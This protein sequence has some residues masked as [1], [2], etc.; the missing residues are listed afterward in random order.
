MQIST[1]VLQLEGLWQQPCW[2]IAS[3]NGIETMIVAT[4][5]GAAQG[6]LG[7][8]LT[9][10]SQVFQQKFLLNRVGMHTLDTAC[11]LDAYMSLPLETGKHCCLVIAMLAPLRDMCSKSPHSSIGPAAVSNVPMPA[12]GPAQG[13]PVPAP[14]STITIWCSQALT[15]QTYCFLCSGCMHACM[16]AYRHFS[17]SDTSWLSGMDCLQLGVARGQ[18][19]LTDFSYGLQ[20]I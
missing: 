15:L 14:H 13:L 10:A 8:A 18:L 3:Q 6:P 1:V 4:I 2:Q 7:D 9:H 12:A 17:C 16:Y 20:V 19:C 11:S 5:L